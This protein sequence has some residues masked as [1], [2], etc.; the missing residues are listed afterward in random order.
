MGN[1]VSNLVTNQ[2]DNQKSGAQPGWLGTQSMNNISFGG[3]AVSPAACL[4]AV[5]SA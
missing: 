1:E 2:D 5:P 3:N 4:P